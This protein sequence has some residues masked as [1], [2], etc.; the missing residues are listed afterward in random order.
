MARNDR[1]GSY[2]FAV[3]GFVLWAHLSN[4]ASFQ[5]ISPI[6]PLITDDYGISYARAG[7]LVGVVMMMQTAFGLPAGIL[8]GRWGLKRG[9]AGAWFLMALPTLSALSPNYYGLLLLRLAQGIGSA[10]MIPATGRLIMQW[11]RPRQLSIVNSLNPAGGALGFVVALST[12]A[13]LAEVLGWQKV[14]GLFG[15]IGLGGATAWLIWGKTR[16]GPGDVT[17]TLTWGDVRDVLSDRSLLLLSTA[18]GAC[19]SEYTALNAWLPSFYN[20]AR[21]MSLTEAGFITSLLPLMGIFAVLLGGF[22]PSKIGPKRLFFIVPGAM[23]GVGVLGTFLID[24][25]A[26]TYASIIVLG[27]GSWLFLPSVLTTPMELP[28]ATSQKVAVAWAWIT[29]CSGT[30]MFI[31]PLV[32][33]VMRDAFG[34]FVPG[35]LVMAALPWSMFVAGF[36]LPKTP[37]EAAELGSPPVSP[38]TPSARSHLRM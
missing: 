15:A 22:L 24:H 7:L 18:T 5:A 9:L 31:S 10:F 38:A 14:L 23:A 20:E 6:L 17:T 36:L 19:F 29:V 4:S 33:G 27:L 16:D 26:L 34:S 25:T 21:G 2:T 30:G 11:I 32:V 28:S 13:P 12:A 35:F 8:I 37:P 3:G 1:A